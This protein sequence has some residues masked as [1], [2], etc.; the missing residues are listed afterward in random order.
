MRA[1]VIAALLAGS[2]LPAPAAAQPAVPGPETRC[3]ITDPRVAELSGLVAG[4]D[5]WYA[6]NDGGTAAT[7]LVL[8]KDCRVER[9]IVGDVDP[10]D[11]EDLARAAD[12]TFWLAD[13]G[14]NDLDRGTV[15]L[16][17]LTAEGEATLYRLTYPDGPHDTEA[18]LL[19][20]DGTPYLVTKSTSGVAGVYRPA[21]RL[22][23]PGPTPLERVGEAR[24]SAT[25]TR[26]GPIPAIIGSVTVTGGATSHDGAVVALRT[27]TDAYLWRVEGDDVP[28]ALGATP[29]RIPLPG[30][31]QGEAIAFEPDGSLVSA[32]EGVGE[33]VRVVPGAAALAAP[34]GETPAAAPAERASDGAA[35]GGRSGGEDGLPA[36]P[37]A[38]V[39]VAFVGGVY[40]FLRRR[41]ARR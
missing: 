34:A 13:A 29:V 18:L 27:Y 2:A 15:A 11:V 7:V 8:T 40:L 6:V 32:S 31:T 3:V 36:L 1:A 14:D 9:E 28:A 16:I 37:A 41:A 35:T 24:L 33:P 30:E 4:E 17:S 12:G 39:T 10:Y 19:A 25:S 20:G 23:S 38:V 5:H 21:A 22:A 26:G